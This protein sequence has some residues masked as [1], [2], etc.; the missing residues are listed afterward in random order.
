MSITLIRV[1]NDLSRAENARRELLKS[2]IEPSHVELTSKEDEAGPV[3]G[4]FATGNDESGENAFLRRF[5]SVVGGEEQTYERDYRDAIQRG[6]VM[7]AVQADNDEECE[8]ASGILKHFGG[9]DFNQQTP[10]QADPH[11]QPSLGDAA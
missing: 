5:G 8:L 4:N 2:G 1:Y 3:Q 7:L 6:K 11:M 10:S 9:I